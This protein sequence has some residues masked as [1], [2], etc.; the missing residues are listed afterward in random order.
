MLLGNA[1][2]AIPRAASVLASILACAQAMGAAEA[3][4]SGSGRLNYAEMVS[5]AHA[6]AARMCESGVCPGDFVLCAIRSGVSLPLA[7]LSAMLAGAVI[8]PVDAAWPEPRRRHVQRA[9]GAGIVLVSDGGQGSAFENAFGFEIAARPAA[10][11]TIDAGHIERGPLLYGFFTSG[12]T[13]APKC[14]LN[15]H[16]GVANRFRYMTKRFGSGHVV[17]QNSSPLFDSSIWQMIWPLMSGGVAVLPDHRGP[18]DLEQVVGDISAHRVTMTDFVPTLF[19]ELVKAMKG[20]RIDAC[21]LA[22]LRHVLIGGEQIDARAV[23]EFR[24]MLP[25]CDVVNTYGHTEASIGMVF[26]SVCDADGLDIP[27]GAPIDNTYV[28]VTDA[29]LAC[30]ADGEVGE[31]VVGGVCVG[32]GYLGRPDLTG[33]AFLPNPFPDIPGERVYRSGDF[34]RRRADGLLEYC[35]RADDQIK[36]NGVRI[37]L[38]EVEEAA[39][40]L[41]PNLTDARA[42]V[43]DIPDQGRLLALAYGAVAPVEQRAMRAALATH[44]PTSHVP[45]LYLHKQALPVS[46]S[47]KTDRQA[48]LAEVSRLAAAEHSRAASDVRTAILQMFRMV[49]GDV[50]LEEGD[51]FFDA[52]GDSL[53]AVELA[54]CLEKLIGRPV[55]WG[56]IYRH[57]SAAAFAALC[58]SDSAS[59]SANGTLPV[60]SIKGVFSKPAAPVRSVLLTGATGF[61]GVHVLGALL[62]RKD[63]QLYLVVRAADAVTA[64]ARVNHAYREA[65]G[66]LPDRPDLHVVCG[67][68]SRP[69][70]GL[71][72]HTWADL[73]T[74]VD[75]VIHCGAEVNFMAPAAQLYVTNVLGAAE[76]VH[77][78]GAG[79][80]KRLHLVSSLA[81]REILGEAHA[82]TVH[83]RKGYAVTKWLAEQVVLRASALGLHA[84]A[85]RVD[86]VLPS[87]V[88]GFG[89]VR[90][91]AHLM[92]KRCVALGLAPQGAGMLGL[93]TADG[94][95]AWLASLVGRHTDA[96]YSMYQVTGN[97]YVDF[98]DLVTRCAGQLGR[99]VRSTTMDEV[100]QAFAGTAD[101]SDLLL[102]H[103][104]RDRR[105]A[106]LFT[107]TDSRISTE[108]LPLRDLLAADAGGILKFIERA[109][110]CPDSR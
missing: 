60:P 71:D 15:H 82:G 110:A 28:K 9:T 93:L 68:L 65:F 73:A 72:D 79:R 19:A 89:N 2:E 25:G 88:T 16:A 81:A 39:K 24:R 41:F 91:L 13:G 90:S 97:G 103:L 85:Y 51:D 45:R 104:L 69:Q 62:A 107:P 26:H 86:D 63:L 33:Q 58:A 18:W 4:R 30:V 87:A 32:A 11:R 105:G 47:G 92:L 76:A 98:H 67:D 84:T 31:I 17:Y 80:P 95:G 70:F 64:R 66:A 36:L 3:L 43:V 37:E 20:G 96:P 78:C 48:L 106:V 100:V 14:A 77:F 49:S 8:V 5:A 6:N 83:Q 22:T 34:G 102:A 10:G 50:A 55:L 40:A 61:V 27:L 44:L 59:E 38:A 74:R 7:W 46:E 94:F 75:E 42:F 101:A 29:N 99:P 56:E 52:G 57:P 12:S 108:Q 54:T 35:G 109:S 21:R 53:A 23:H 1:P